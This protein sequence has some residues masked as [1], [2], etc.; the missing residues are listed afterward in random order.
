MWA[1]GQ[2]SGQNRFGFEF[3]SLV[4]NAPQKERLFC[5][6]GSVCDRLEGRFSKRFEKSVRRGGTNAIVV[7]L[8]D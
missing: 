2:R 3:P 5:G 8:F 6:V 1:A 4:I 7:R